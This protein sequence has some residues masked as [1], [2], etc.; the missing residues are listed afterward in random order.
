MIFCEMSV[1]DEVELIPVF[2]DMPTVNP[3]TV[4]K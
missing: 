4:G 3:V 2:W 1:F